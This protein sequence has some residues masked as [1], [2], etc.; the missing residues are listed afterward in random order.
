MAEKLLFVDS[1][2]AKSC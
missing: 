1:S 2:A